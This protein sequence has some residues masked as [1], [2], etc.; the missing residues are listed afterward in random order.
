[1]KL[2]IDK[3][4]WK[5]VH[6]GDVVKKVVNKIAPFEY[7]SDIV[8]EGGHINKRDFHIRKHENKNELG[9]LGP[10]FHMG[11]KK[12]QILYVSRNPHLMKV[13]YPDFDGI[14]SNT[15]FIL[16][17]KNEEVLRNDLIPFLMHSDT[18]IEQSVG[19]VRGGVNPYVNWGD[20]ASIEFLLPP[21]ELQAELAL[22][23]WS[24]DEVI[25]KDLS[26]EKGIRQ[27]LSTE[28][29]DICFRNPD[30]SSKIYKISDIVD[31]ITSGVS[32]NSTDEAYTQGKVAV[33]KT[34][35]ITG[36]D[37]KSTEAKIII[38]SDL[39]LLKESIKANSILINRKNTKGLVGS[40]KFIEDD[41]ENLFLPDLIW[42]IQVNPEKAYPKFIWY[43]LNTPQLRSKMTALSNGTNESMVNIAKK[44]FVGIELSL[45]NKKIQKT[46][47]DKADQL[48]T[49][50]KQVRHKL[51]SSKSLKKSIIN[52]VF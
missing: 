17:T 9:Y 31:S 5:K 16:E 44:S 52:Q 42:N 25:E 45:P 19:N 37:F 40:T 33:L 4:T 13:G 36:D 20:L 38:D 1:M 35:A 46:F 27:K 50:I 26:V 32:V 3:S 48:S 29:V 8:I 30:I 47:L 24:M 28:A 39:G 6:F 51:D 41:F 18:F 43:M 15:T 49:L 2:S 11:F 7:H 22:L 14:C 21:I 10:A 12:R 23:L 34:S